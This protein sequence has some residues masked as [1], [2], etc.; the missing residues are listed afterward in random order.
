MSVID[1]K[2]RVFGRFNLVDTAVAL[3]IV[4]LIPLAYATVLLFR[5]ARPQIESV[6]KVDIT[7]EE[8]RIVSGGSLLAAKIKVKGSGFNPMLRA[9]IGDSPALGFVFENP[10]SADVLVGPMPPGA[11]DLVLRDGVQEVARLAKSVVIDQPSTRSVRAEGWLTNLPPDFAHELKNGAPAFAPH[12]IE[13]LGPAGPAQSHLTVGGSGADIPI[14][15]RLER[16]AVITLQCDPTG[17]ELRTGQEPCTIASQPVSGAGPATVVMPGPVT[18]GFT[19]VELFPTTA[20][21]RARVRVTLDG[22]ADVKTGDRDSLLDDR[23]ALVSAVQGRSVTVD[24]GLD[25]AR[26]GWQYRGQMIKPGASFRLRTDRYEATGQVES[27][28]LPEPAK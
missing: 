28:T 24:V 12:T 25:R 22:S 7:T 14:A 16:R 4:V 3:F 10:N 20:P 13:A 19:V 26:D 5:P 8:R 17:Q 9:Y 1:S 15:G 11:H 21:A 27:V 18:V 2:G 6:T 23:A